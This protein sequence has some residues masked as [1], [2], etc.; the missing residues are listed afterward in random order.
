LVE[1]RGLVERARGE[2][3]GGEGRGEEGRER[4]IGRP[5][6][7]L[8]IATREPRDDAVVWAWDRRAEQ[9][10]RMECDW[11]AHTPAFGTADAAKMGEPAG[12]L[13]DANARDDQHQYVGRSLWETGRENSR[14][15]VWGPPPLETQQAQAQD[16]PGLS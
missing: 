2:G 3:R 4:G 16:G 6:A 14:A 5:R 8:Y 11:A 10:A 15:V 7:T 1:G 13:F 9:L 12:A